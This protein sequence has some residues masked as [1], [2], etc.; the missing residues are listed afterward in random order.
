MIVSKVFFTADQNKVDKLF[1]AAGFDK[2]IYP[3]DPVALKIHFGEPGNTAYLKPRQVKP[4][5]DRIMAVGGKPFYTD[6][7][8]LYKGPRNNTKDHLQVA[9][10]H[11]FMKEQAGADAVI[12]E[13][14]DFEVIDVSLKHFKKVY[15][16]GAAARAKV[17][18]A[19]T[20]FKGH[21]TTGFGGA[22]KNIG[23]GLG[24][25]LG[26]LRMHQDCKNC[27]QAKTCQ[28]NKTIESC[29]VGSPTLVQEKI[30]E[31]VFGAVKNKRAGYI[32]FITSVSPNCDCYDHSDPPIVPDIGVLAS[33]DPVAIDQIS[34]DLVN[35]T[36]GRIESKDKFRA[37]YPNVDWTVQLEYAEK[38]GLGSRKY[39]IIKL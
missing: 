12:S 25:R 6:C 2:L 39:E 11:G 5:A 1:E 4:I 17:L 15:I 3:D 26:K 33:D 8:T 20:H 32:N 19:L 30:V 18:I 36:E 13:E 14:N 38:I 28:K 27:P 34:V 37:L 16:G 10:D 9:K 7:N 23:M 29:W 22:L 21:D 35:Q 31:Y 24:T